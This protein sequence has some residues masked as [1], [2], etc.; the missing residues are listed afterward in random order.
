MPGIACLQAVGQ[1]GVFPCCEADKPAARG[2]EGYYH[3]SGVPRDL[4]ATP[5]GRR[6]RKQK[7]AASR[8]ATRSFIFH[9][10]PGIGR[11]KTI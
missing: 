4:G 5:L 6:R 9:Q 1:G 10:L 7:K 11:S 8:F 2:G 3:R